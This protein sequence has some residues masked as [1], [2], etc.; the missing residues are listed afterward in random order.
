MILMYMIMKSI[1]FLIIDL[2]D[3]QVIKVI[4]IVEEVLQ[5]I[6]LDILMHFKILKDSLLLNNIIIHVK[7]LHLLEGNMIMITLEMQIISI[8]IKNVIGQN[9]I[10]LKNHILNMFQKQKLYIDKFKKVILIIMNKCMKLIIFQ[11]QNKEKL[12]I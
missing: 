2:A 7:E 11:F 12:L 3:I 1:I 8:M 9:F 10:Q 6:E 5:I 4:V